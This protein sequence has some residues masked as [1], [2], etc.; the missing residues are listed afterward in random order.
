ME[1]I[2]SVFILGSGISCEAGA[3]SLSN[4]LPIMFGKVKQEVKGASKNVKSFNDLE[5]AISNPY[6]EFEEIIFL[7]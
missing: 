1:K 7:K 3:P 5:L 4:F 6:L 2:K